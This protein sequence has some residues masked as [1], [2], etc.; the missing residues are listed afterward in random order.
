MMEYL[1]NLNIFDKILSKVFSRYTNKIYRLGVM[2]GFN[3]ENQKL[4]EKM[5]K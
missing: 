1:Q 3:W 4:W 5:K 2:E